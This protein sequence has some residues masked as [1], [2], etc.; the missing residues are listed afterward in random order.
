MFL[1]LL[2]VVATTVSGGLCAAMPGTSHDVSSQNRNYTEILL[3]RHGQTDWNLEQ[4]MQGWADIPL[5][6]TGIDQAER[7]AKEMTIYHSN[8][9]TTVYS[10][11]LQ[12][13]VLTAQKTM[14]AFENA[15][16]ATMNLVQMPSLREYNFGTAEGILSS[17][18]K[19]LYKELEEKLLEMY[20]DRKERWDYTVIPGSETNNELVAR[21]K[22]ALTE[23][24]NNHPGEKVAVFAHGRLIYNLMVDTEDSKTSLPGLPNCA[25]VHFRYYHDQPENPFKYI[26]K[27]SLIE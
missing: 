10:S 13:A 24:A 5:N 6:E 12:R 8:L 19:A 11:D 22:E 15:G 9:A 20:P 4:R 1:F 27:E 21:T 25:V 3:I 14:D 2:C 23:I 26:M 17:E 16:I 7:L 18:S